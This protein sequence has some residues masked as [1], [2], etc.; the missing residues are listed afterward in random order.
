MYWHRNQLTRQLVVPVLYLKHR[1]LFTYWL[2]P[3]LCDDALVGRDE[4]Y[5]RIR[6]AVDLKTTTL[7]RSR[8]VVGTAHGTVV[9]YSTQVAT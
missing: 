2:H 8:P 4:M 1:L 6:C 9:K 3:F 7:L 5:D